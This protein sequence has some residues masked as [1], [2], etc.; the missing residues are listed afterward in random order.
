MNKVEIMLENGTFEG[1]ITMHSINSQFRATRISRTDVPDY[2]VDLEYPGI[3]MLL[4]GTDTVYVGQTAMNTIVKRIMSTHSGT[5]DSSWHT[6]LAFSCLNSTIS[7]NELLYLENAM[8]EYAHKNYTHCATTSPSITQCNAAYR[9]THYKL[10]ASQIKICNQYLDDM[11]FYI[12]R[13]G[14]TIFDA[15]VTP[16]VVKTDFEPISPTDPGIKDTV[17]TSPSPSGGETVSTETE[18]FFFASPSRGSSGKAV[19][20]IHLGHSKKRPALLLAGSKVSLKVSDSFAGSLSVKS[21]RAQLESDGTLV[22]G[23]L[24]K[25]YLFPSQSGAGQFL[26]GTSFDG[27]SNW[28]LADGTP[29]KELLE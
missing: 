28:K 7:T 11:K 14:E 29:L 26:N 20:G 18:T 22:D 4:I 17:P 1:P 15:S 24:T 27:N 3:Y 16:T 2:S 25:D 5:I 8:T 13:F 21:L 12:E 19:I 9:K 23:E 6:V 10:T